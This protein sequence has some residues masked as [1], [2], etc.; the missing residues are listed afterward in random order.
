MHRGSELEI[1]RKML[2]DRAVDVDGFSGQQL[3][4]QP[5]RCLVLLWFLDRVKR[6]PA[7]RKKVLFIDARH[8]FRQID[9]AHRDWTPEQI[10]FISNIVRVYRGEAP[11]PTAEA[12]S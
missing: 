10:E 7:Q 6:K 1:R 8:H 5:S 4:L 3:L 2:E 9:R 11:K 12:S